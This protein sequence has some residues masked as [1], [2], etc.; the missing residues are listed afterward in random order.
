MRETD[1]SSFF[2]EL[3]R[4]AWLKR[5]ALAA[6]GTLASGSLLARAAP[7]PVPESSKK[8]GA[9]ILSPEYGQPSPHESDVVRRPTGLTP[10]Q[11]VQRIAQNGGNLIRVWA[12]QGDQNA[13]GDFYL[14]YPA[15]TY[16]EAQALRL[17]DCRSAKSAK[18]LGQVI[19]LRLKSVLV[20]RAIDKSEVFSLSRADLVSESD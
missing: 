8:L 9:P 4:R 11:Y 16:R 1:P 10:T 2:S 14:E 13:N 15:G 18:A 20:I 12:E 6:G 17:D 5:T 3:S 19:N 7:L